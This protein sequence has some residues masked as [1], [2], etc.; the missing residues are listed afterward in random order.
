MKIRRISV[1]IVEISA[2]MSRLFVSKRRNRSGGLTLSADNKQR[3]E[4]LRPVYQSQYFQRRVRYGKAMGLGR[5]PPHP[6]GEHIPRASPDRRPVT[7]SEAGTAAV[8]PA[9][10]GDRVPSNGVPLSPHPVVQIPATGCC[11]HET[12][13]DLN[14][15]NTT[16]C[17]CETGPSP[18]T[19]PSVTLNA[20][21]SASRPPLPRERLFCPR[22]GNV[23]AEC[24]RQD[25]RAV[26]IGYSVL[27]PRFL[28]FS[29]RGCAGS[30][31]L[32]ASSHFLSKRKSGSAPHSRLV[33]VR[34]RGMKRT[35]RT[36]LAF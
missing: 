30:L 23:K 11:A 28:T 18:R 36:P 9:D 27:T 33:E 26:A 35:S 3:P 1:T 34:L 25:A 19:I 29:R 7:A 8:S 20:F 16:I 6:R 24:R 32:S 31:P 17:P 5:L 13:R 12:V 21:S 4:L 15:S 14:L 22:A 2:L 10:A